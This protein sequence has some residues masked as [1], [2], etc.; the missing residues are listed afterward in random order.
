[1]GHVSTLADLMTIRGTHDLLKK[2]LHLLLA[3]NNPLIRC[4]YKLSW[5]IQTILI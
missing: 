1:M 3:N 5:F 4:C 2:Q